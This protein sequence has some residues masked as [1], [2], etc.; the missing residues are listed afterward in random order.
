MAKKKLYKSKSSF[1]LKRLH[2]S[3]SYGN[4]YER[5]YTTIYNGGSVPSGQIPVYGSPSFKLSVRAGLN[6]QKKYNYGEWVV[7]TCDSEKTGNI[8]WTLD[9]M[10]AP[11]KNDSKIIL[12]PHTRK[13]TDFVCYGSAVELIDN[14]IKNIIARFPGELYISDRKISDTGLLDIG[15]E[16]LPANGLIVENPLEID[17]LQAVRE[18][19][20][21]YKI[22]APSRYMCESQ[23]DYNIITKNGTIIETKDDT[24]FWTVSPNTGN[25]CLTNGTK[26]ADVTFGNNDTKI[27]IGCYYYEEEILYICNNS[28]YIGYHIRPN[29]KVV[30]DFFENLN[31]FEKV[32]LN[33]YTDYTSKFETY[34]ETDNGWAVTEETY[35]WP[36]DKGDWNLSLRGFNYSEYVSSLQALAST[37]DELYTDAIW[38]TMTH[39]GIYNMDFT[40]KNNDGDFEGVDATKIRKTLNIFGRQFDEIKKY[41]DNIKNTNSISYDQDKNL[42][43]YFLSDNLELSG[44]E[45]KVILNN[46]SNDEISD[47]IYGSRSLGFTVGDANNDFLRR[48]KLNSKSILS[49]KGTK[50]SI[51]EIMSLF[52]FHS[53]DWINSYYTKRIEQLKTLIGKNPAPEIKS[54]LE[55]EFNRLT[56]EE[57]KALT[58]TFDLYEYVYIA[59][60]Y[61]YTPEEGETKNIEQ[62]VDDVKYLNVIKD[63]GLGVGSADELEGMDYYEGLPVVEVTVGDKTMIVPWFDKNKSYDSNM[64]FQMKGG[65]GLNE[66]IMGYQKYDYTVSK[67]HFVREIEDLYTLTYRSIDE[68]GYYYIGNSDVYCKVRDI[69]EHSNENGWELVAE[70]KIH[71]LKGIIDNN[72]GNN[73]HTGDYDNGISYVEA[74]NDLFKYSTFNNSRYDDSKKNNQYGF[75]TKRQH[76]DTKVLYYHN[77][78]TDNELLNLD[79]KNQLRGANEITPHNFFISEDE[80]ETDNKIKYNEASSLSVINSKE[81][82]I[83]FSINHENFIET[84]VLPYV[85]QIIPSTSIFSY[86]YSIFSVCNGGLACEGIPIY[87]TVY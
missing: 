80:D 26:I 53:I 58:K 72:K 71:E 4:I 69:N 60:D 64:Y 70:D 14:T 19:E 76:A 44:W 12:K 22:Y 84:D 78:D 13:L 85:K 65:W 73:P 48:L 55:S 30:N 31:D 86:N 11:N 51:E 3:G 27:T 57:E 56:T 36:I 38:R 68:K 25:S 52:G 87:G 74:F 40:S 8:N 39:D 34:D 83:R 33:R 10:P 17:I 46:I 67:I 79:R 9:C 77:V 81:F 42:P 18:D 63:S 37:C 61:K 43:D 20:P 5:D 7:N 16:G 35:K 49:K 50:Q 54:V 45:T 2:Q 66:K 24:P 75:S 29:E 82:H 1:T 28:S 21:E 15:V 23:Y 47:P 32:I 59:D 62:F 6:S 41:I